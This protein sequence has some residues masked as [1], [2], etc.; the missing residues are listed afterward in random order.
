MID[1]EPDLTIVMVLD[2]EEGL[3]RGNA[4]NAVATVDEGRF[5]R[6]GQG[7]QD[8]L[9]A[10]F[11]MLP[12]H[13]PDRCLPVNASGGIEAVAERV[14]AVIGPRLARPRLETGALSGP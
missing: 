11:A 12:A 8:R 6:M 10:G 1:I 4:R 9:V 3:R 13:F 2:P 7:F 5:E 14:M